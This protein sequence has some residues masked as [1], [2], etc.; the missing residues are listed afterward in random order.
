MNTNLSKNDFIHNII[1]VFSLLA[2][3][4]QSQ[5]K[6]VPWVL[7]TGQNNENLQINSIHKGF[8][9]HNTILLDSGSM[10]FLSSHS[11]VICNQQETYFTK[12]NQ[13]FHEM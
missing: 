1:L 12:D 4:A 6:P 8:C 5:D 10:N 2:S 11:Q 7:R 13:Y 3:K 9:L